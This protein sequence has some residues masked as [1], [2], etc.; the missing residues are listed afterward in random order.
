VLAAVILISTSTIKYTQDNSLFVILWDEISPLRTMRFP[1]RFNIVFNF[2]ALIYIFI[3]ID[4]YI[5][6]KKQVFKFLGILLSLLDIGP[7]L[8]DGS[9]EYVDKE[10]ETILDTPKNLSICFIS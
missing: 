6:S 9:K 5:N 10:E 7:F 1:I 8:V 3:Y 2:I 4:N